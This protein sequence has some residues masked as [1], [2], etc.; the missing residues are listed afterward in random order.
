MLTSI[1]RNKNE[2]I[3]SFFYIVFFLLLTLFAAFRPVGFDSD[4]IGYMAWIEED[5]YKVMAEP[6]FS[7]IIDFWALLIPDEYIARM[8]L[9]TYAG[10][11]MLFLK[12]AFEGFSNRRTQAFIFYFY[13]FTLYSLLLKL[14]SD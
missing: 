6:S 9:V 5:L 1:K 12:S 3:Q 2:T 14:E 4:S 13:W 11:N 7:I 10:L 8:V